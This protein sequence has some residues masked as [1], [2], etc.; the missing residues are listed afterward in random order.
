MF[1]SIRVKTLMFFGGGVFTGD[2]P[3]KMLERSLEKVRK[4]KRKVEEN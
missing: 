2:K 3:L 1:F 4:L